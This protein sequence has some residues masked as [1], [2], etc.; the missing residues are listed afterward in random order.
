MLG[1]KVKNKKNIFKA[2]KIAALT[3]ILV[4]CGIM[5][6]VQINTEHNIFQSNTSERSLLEK[7]CTDFKGAKSTVTPEWNLIT[8]GIQRIELDGIWFVLINTSNEEKLSCTEGQCRV[9]W[10]TDAINIDHRCISL[11]NFKW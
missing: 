10:Y 11:D 5:F 6:F 7:K 3:S 8:D 1:Y 9:G 2:L 4:M